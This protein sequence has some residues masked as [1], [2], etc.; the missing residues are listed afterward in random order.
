MD[1]RE[2]MKTLYEEDKK[3]TQEEVNKILTKHKLWLDTDG[4]EGEIAIFSGLDLSGM[5]FREADLTDACFKGAILI[6]ADFH[7]ANCTG[8]DFT[9][10]DCENAI[11]TGADLTDARCYDSNFVGAKLTGA[12]I[13]DAKGLENFECLEVFYG[14][15]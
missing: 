4:E 13:T 14:F 11:F 2:K 5:K 12:N 6:G 15:F 1:N 7:G 10:A 8:A 9:Y 3:L